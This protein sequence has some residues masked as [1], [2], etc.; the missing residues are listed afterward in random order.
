MIKQDNDIDH[1]KNSTD[2]DNLNNYYNYYD[3]VSYK[4]EADNPSGHR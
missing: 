3:C 1:D 2:G 4:E